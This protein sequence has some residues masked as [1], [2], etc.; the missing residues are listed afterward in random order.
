MES[1]DPGQLSITL[2]S[3]CKIQDLNTASPLWVFD[4][5]FTFFFFTMS[6]K[7]SVCRHL[8]FFFIIH[9]TEAC[10]RGLVLVALTSE[11]DTSNFMRDRNESFC[12][13]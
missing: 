9:V 7:V 8:L 13:V 11:E 4:F 5:F 3:V 6:V 10:E 2:Y 1:M 12:F